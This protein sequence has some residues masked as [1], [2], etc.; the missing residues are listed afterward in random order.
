VLEKQLGLFHKDEEFLEKFIE[1]LT[2][3]EQQFVNECKI[4]EKQAKNNVKMSSSFG[5][6]NQIQRLSN[7]NEESEKQSKSDQS[8]ASQLNKHQ[9][10][11]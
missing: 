1:L 7:A 6:L 2:Q 9:E 8:S 10:K 3:L 5:L 11:L 4:L